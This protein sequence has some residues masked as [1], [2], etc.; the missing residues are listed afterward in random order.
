MIA[1]SR[2]ARLAPIPAL[3]LCGALLAGCAGSRSAYAPDAGERLV[4]LEGSHNFRDLGGYRTADGRQLRW[5]RLYRSDTLSG[6]TDDDVDALQPLR[7][8]TIVD[9]RSERERR[10]DPDRVLELAPDTVLAL[11]VEAVGLD[12]VTLRDKIRTGGIMALE[13]EAVMLDAYRAFETHAPVWRAFFDQLEQEESYPLVFHCTAGK[14][15]TGFAAALVLL[16]LGV[17]EETVVEDY[18]ATNAYQQTMREAVLRWVPLYSFFR[19][20]PEDLLPLL[21]ARREYLALSLE[22]VRARWGSVDAYL[23]EALGL[24][25]E[26]LDAL[27]ARLLE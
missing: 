13:L 8:R 21:E 14:D 5:E 20:E 3:L 26:R 23:E 4:P 24:T 9:L 27:R 10:E 25:P 18:L 19:T 6:L 7:L 12:P 16:A 1:V 2:R 17:P 22:A 15:R 11:E